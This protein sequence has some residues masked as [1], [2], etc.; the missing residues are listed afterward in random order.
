[1]NGTEYSKGILAWQKG[2]FHP[3]PL[4]VGF[5]SP[6]ISLLS[7]VLP[8]KQGWHWRHIWKTVTL[9]SGIGIWFEYQT[10][11]QPTIP[12][13]SLFEWLLYSNVR[14]SDPTKPDV[15]LIQFPAIVVSYQGSI[16]FKIPWTFFFLISSVKRIIFISWS[17]KKFKNL[18]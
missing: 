16:I 13:C 14:Y 3:F 10:S 7:S 4:P 9:L 15:A 5:W 17:W 6:L 12:R 11:V 18:S 2:Y 1:M 8:Y